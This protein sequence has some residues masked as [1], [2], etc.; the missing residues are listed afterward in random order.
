M[1]GIGFYQ[2]SWSLFVCEG[3]D[4]VHGHTNGHWY[5]LQKL[6]SDK[7]LYVCTCALVHCVHE[8]YML[9]GGRE[10]FEEADFVYQEDS[11]CSVVLFS[12]ELTPV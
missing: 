1:G 4:R 5:H 8:Q 6:D 11:L 2:I 3:W 10:A 12:R 7:E 9:D